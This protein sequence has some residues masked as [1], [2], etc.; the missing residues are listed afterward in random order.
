MEVLVAWVGGITFAAVVGRYLM[1]ARRDAQLRKAAAAAMAGSVADEAVG[2]AIADDTDGW[3]GG[4][5]GDGG[6]GAD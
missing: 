3:G 4:E 6:D 5:G 1:K 2:I